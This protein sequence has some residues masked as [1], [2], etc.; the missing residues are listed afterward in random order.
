MR[1]YLA[2]PLKLRK[3][4]RQWELIM[5]RELELELWNPFYDGPEREQIEDLDAGKYKNE[6]AYNKSLKP[7]RTVE[8]DLRAIDACQGTLAWIEKGV[9]SLGTPME[10]MYTLLKKKPVY[11]IAP[12]WQSHV[13]LRY[14]AKK[15][16]GFIARGKEDAKTRLLRLAGKRE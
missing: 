12:D 3:D 10:V 1:L 2:H 14:I 7:K 16:R 8:G 15:S 11:I 6:D 4:I 9:S 13:W 5:E